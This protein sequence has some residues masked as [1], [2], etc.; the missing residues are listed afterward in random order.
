MKIYLSSNFV[1]KFKKLPENIKE[2]ARNREAIFKLNPFDPRL[3]THKLH[4]KQSS[5]WAYSIDYGYRIAFV[6]LKHGDVLY[7]DVGTHN[8]VYT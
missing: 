3:E 5:E 4:G 8:E 6:L 7:T 1:R 2:K